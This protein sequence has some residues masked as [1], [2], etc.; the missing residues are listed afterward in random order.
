M[1]LK[2]P[3]APSGTFA[4]IRTNHYHGGLDLRIGGDDGIGTPVYAPAD[5]YVSRVRISAY[6]GGK[7]LYIN[8]AG[9]I[10]TVYL[11]LDGYHGAI[12]DY[13]QQVQNAEQ[14]YTFDTVV[15][16]GLLPVK[17][18]DLIAYAGNSGMSGGPHLH[19]EVRNTLNQNTLNPLNYGITL[20]D[21]LK[22]TIR[23][24]RILPFNGFTRIEGSKHPYLLADKDTLTIRGRFYLGVYATDVSEGSTERNGY[25]KIDIWVDGVPFFQYQMTEIPSSDSR[26]INA[27]LDYEHYLSTRQGYIITRRLVGDP[28]RPARTF[29]DGSIGFIES[30]TTLHRITVAVS[31]FNGN[32]AVRRFFV[33]NSLET[34]VPMHEVPEHP[35]MR[36]HSDSIFYSQPLSIYR[37][38]YQIEMPKGMLYY[39]DLL[40]HGDRKDRRHISPIVMVKPW[41]SPYPPNHTFQLRVPIPI[42][43]EP[44]Q[45]VVCSLRNDKLNACTTRIVERRTE[46]KYGS[47]LEADARVFGEFVVALD[48]VAPNV[49]PSN[50]KDGKTFKGNV[51]RLKISDNL[52][53]IKEYRCF[54]NGEWVLA[55]FDGKYAQLSIALARQYNDL[56]REGTNTLRVFVTDCC[57]NEKDVTYTFSR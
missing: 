52:S 43:Y 6:D 24:I 39:D 18:G 21:T 27:Q 16:P 11:H 44:T 35:S 56:L 40:I 2:L 1:P 10:T 33:R 13:V 55:E 5:G 22:P 45:L 23:G 29:G 49:S 53:G 17:K 42:G 15:E 32:Q 34:L 38:E 8:H 25:D 50:F 3:A 46:G 9:Y 20:S 57:G 47:W 41:K 48:S 30:D 51:I 12:A 31:D 54:L 28:I 26:A 14:C 19:Y 4:E 37:G 36:Q 7:M